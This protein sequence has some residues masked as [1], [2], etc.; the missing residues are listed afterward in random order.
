[1]RRFRSGRAR[2]FTLVELLVVIA[3]IGILVGLL[4]PAVQAAREAA[5]RM[6]CTNNIKQLGLAAHNFES[7]YKRFPP[8][9]SVPR[10]GGNVNQAWLA[11]EFGSHSGIGHLAHLLPY[12]E[13][14]TIYSGIETNSNMNPD[15]DGV[16]AASGTPRQL[17]NRYWWDTDS[18]DFA[19]WKL[20]SLLCPSDNPDGGTFRSVLF[21]FAFLNNADPATTTGAFSFYMEGNDNA[22]WHSTVGKTNYV[23]NGGRSGRIGAR[24]ANSTSANLPADS[25]AGPFGIRSKTKISDF[26]D[27][28][29]NTFLFGEVTGGFSN[30]CNNSGREMSFWWIS[31]GPTFTRFNA[32]PTNG[33]CS[34]RWSG[35]LARAD[36][37][38]PRKF[39]SFHAGGVINFCNGD[40]SVRSVPVN[41]EGNVWLFLSGM[42]EGQV[43]SVPE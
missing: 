32:F 22:P 18:W 1:M 39:S 23:G 30:P 21:P 31:A 6:Q 34:A 17:T 11:V 28:T 41:M 9:L 40:G 29:S 38:E 2:G 43:A 14:N 26:T 13:Q 3:I 35:G 42:A 4:L 5:R 19:Q 27:G 15:T 20:P 24:G 25:L 16:G 10:Q 12:I 36:G 7:S 33:D 37:K 8:G